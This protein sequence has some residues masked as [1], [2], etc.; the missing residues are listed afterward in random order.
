MKLTVNYD[1]I[2]RIKESKRGF[3]LSKIIKSNLCITL[4]S[5]LT[6]LLFK[7]N[8]LEILI[9]FIT[10]NSIFNFMDLSRPFNKKVMQDSTWDLNLLLDKLYKLDIRTTMPLLQ[11]SR[12][13]QTNYEVKYRDDKIPVLM[14]KKYITVPLSNGHEETILQKHVFGD[15]NYE[16]SVQEPTKKLQFKTVH[17][18]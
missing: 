10:L 9:Y 5:T 3:R 15:D 18:M 8:K 2:N 4:P 1:L 6:F 13:I 7:E 17:A 16:L 12:V 14:Q 11:E